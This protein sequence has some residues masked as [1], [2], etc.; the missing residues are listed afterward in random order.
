MDEKTHVLWGDDYCQKQGKC[1]D[2][3]FWNNTFVQKWQSIVSTEVCPP[4]GS[5]VVIRNSYLG[6]Q[7]C[8]SFYETLIDHLGDDFHDWDGA[9]WAEQPILRNF[10]DWKYWKQY[11]KVIRF[12]GQDNAIYWHGNKMLHISF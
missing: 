2:S 6:R 9:A 11:V 3:T 12:D 1:C 4:K 10:I 7:F 5:F 8:K